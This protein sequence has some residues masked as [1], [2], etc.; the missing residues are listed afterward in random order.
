[1]R[2]KTSTAANGAPVPIGTGRK[3]SGV[4]LNKPRPRRISALTRRKR[5]APDAQAPAPPRSRPSPSSPPARRLARSGDVLVAE[6]WAARMPPR[7]ATG[8][9]PLHHIHLFRMPKLSRRFMG[10]L[11]AGQHRHPGLAN[12][13]R[14]HLAQR[15]VIRRLGARVHLVAPMIGVVRLAPMQ[16]IIRRPAQPRDHANKTPRLQ[17]DLA[18]IILR[19]RVVAQRAGEGRVR[20][21]RGMA[22]TRQPP[23][24]MAERKRVAEKQEIRPAQNRLVRRAEPPRR[25][26]PRRCAR[27][28]TRRATAPPSRRDPHCPAKA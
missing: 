26:R 7:S 5:S 10:H 8:T 15:R 19:P 22:Q 1:M 27:P 3:F 25:A 28:E 21:K 24:H 2:E 16:A 18:Q 4:H 11:R 9:S 20:A 6:A 13:A 12:P 17:P 23:A 14:D